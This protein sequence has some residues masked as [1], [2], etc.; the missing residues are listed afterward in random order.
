MTRRILVSAFALLLLAAALLPATAA[1]SKVAIVDMGKVTD[2]YT[3]L[4]EKSKELQDWYATQ[5]TYLEKLVDYL[6]LSDQSFAEV[7]ALLSTPQPLPDDKQERLQELTD[8]AAGEEDAF[9]AL[10]AKPDRTAAESE[11]FRKMGDAYT[12]GQNRLAVEQARLNAEYGDSVT[13]AREEFMNK[14]VEV[15]GAIAKKDGYD[16]VLDSGVVLVGGTDITDKILA[17]LNGQ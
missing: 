10:E 11:R 2:N 6:F 1:E 4:Q 17:S 5:R 13:D 15:T 9:R 8:S 14:V 7:K 12:A 3:A 16:L